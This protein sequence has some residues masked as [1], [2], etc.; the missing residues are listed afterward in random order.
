MRSQ[1][2]WYVKSLASEMVIEFFFWGGAPFP[3]F[4]PGSSHISDSSWA[5]WDGFPLCLP[6]SSRQTQIGPR[7]YTE[8]YSLFLFCTPQDL[9]W[10]CVVSQR[11]YTCLSLFYVLASL[12]ILFRILL[13]KAPPSLD[14]ES[15]VPA[16]FLLRKD[17]LLRWKHGQWGRPLILLLLPKPLPC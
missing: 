4:L 16:S 1:C 9:S 17:I 14:A 10:C 7:K 6:P 11:G 5:S 3:L 2:T 8:T 12:S 13:Y 15:N